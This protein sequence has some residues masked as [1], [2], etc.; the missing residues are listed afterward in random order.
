MKAELSPSDRVDMKCAGCATVINYRID[1]KS[2]NFQF[3][4]NNCYYWRFEHVNE[5]E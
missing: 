5:E 1:L 3:Y 4:C 2:N